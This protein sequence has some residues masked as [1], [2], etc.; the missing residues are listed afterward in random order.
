MALHHQEK[1]Q[2]AIDVV[3]RIKAQGA[4]TTYDYVTLVSSLGQLGRTDGVK[5]AIDGFNALALPAAFDPMTVQ[6]AQWYWNGDLF[7]Y[8][9]PYV[10]KM[11]EG[12]RK[13]GVPEGAR[14]G[15][16]ARQI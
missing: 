11:V 8:H 7:D 12:L 2:E 16:S 9:R 14:H 10:D 6:E 1:Y 13:A 4:E 5:E 15:Y 3:E